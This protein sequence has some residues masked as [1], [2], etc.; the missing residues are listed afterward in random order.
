MDGVGR[1]GGLG[2]QR[3]LE[4][5]GAGDGRGIRRVFRRVRR[6]GQ[7]RPTAR[8]IWGPLSLDAGTK[9]GYTLLAGGGGGK[10]FL[11]NG[12][13]GASVTS[14]S[15][16]N[17][18]AADVLVSSATLAVASGSLVISGVVSSTGAALAVPGPG[19]V[20]LAG[21]SGTGDLS[22][23]G[24]RLAIAST[25][26]ARQTPGVMLQMKS[27]TM[28]AGAVL[29]VT[30]HDAMIGH[31]TLSAVAGRIITGFGLGNPGGAAITSSTAVGSTF[32]VPLDADAL[33][34]N[35]SPG[36]AI[37]RVWDGVAITE[38]GTVILKYTYFGDVTLDGK[39]DGLDYATAV[40]HF[41]QS[42][43][44]FTDIGA[45]WLMGD[46][47][48]DGV[49]N[50]ADFSKM[51]GNVGAQAMGAGGLDIGM[52]EIVS[53]PEPASLVLLGLGAIG[54]LKRR[55]SRSKSARGERLGLDRAG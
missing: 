51:A 25:G 20:V 50:G 55:R 4:R 16:V 43:P 10:L 47:N 41:G 32:L 45:A 39:V 53:V 42:T 9:S 26:V 19:V 29:D 38:P 21:Y 2:R 44:G 6:G 12:T 31:T 46:M 27:L 34:G 13:A 17:V 37:G 49:V 15:G 7:F 18:I 30:N 52:P 3:Q 48:F 1:R 5:R 8:G 24:G 14:V 54:L 35:G 28:A 11:D 23:N 33:L 40:A 22:V 36:S